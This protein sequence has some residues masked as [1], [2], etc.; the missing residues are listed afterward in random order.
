MI[1]EDSCIKKIRDFMPPLATV[2]AHCWSDVLDSTICPELDTDGRI[3]VVCTDKGHLCAARI[4]QASPMEHEQ[5][6][7]LMEHFKDKSFCDVTMTQT[8]LIAATFQ[9]EFLF[10]ELSGGR[11]NEVRKTWNLFDSLQFDALA[12]LDVTVRGMQSMYDST[13]QQTLAV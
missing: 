6:V 12:N 8:F 3:F 4:E 7:L 13:Q 10:F 2:T 5:P 11:L 9:A 1:D